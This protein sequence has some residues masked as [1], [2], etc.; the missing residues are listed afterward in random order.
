MY[1][2]SVS[3]SHC[4][5]QLQ[6]LWL[7]ISLFRIKW[8]FVP[9]S[10]PVPFYSL[11]KVQWYWK[12]FCGEKKGHLATAQHCIPITSFNQA[13]KL[14]QW[15]SKYKP[16]FQSSPCRSSVDYTYISYTLWCNIWKEIVFSLA[17]NHLTIDVL[18]VIYFGEK[19]IHKYTSIRIKKLIK[20]NTVIQTS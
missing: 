6:L 8:L 10:F 17:G 3:S 16:S 9:P 7:I 12:V 18:N 13:L 14:C 4:V 15:T 2:S 5:T 11:G 19:A 20:Q 1:Y